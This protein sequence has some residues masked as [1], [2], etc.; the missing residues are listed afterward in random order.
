[1]I[2]HDPAALEEGIPITD[3]S[4]YSSEL[5]CPDSLLAHIFRPAAQSNETIPLLTERIG[6]MREVGF[7]LCAVSQ[8]T[9]LLI[10][11]PIFIFG[12]SICVLVELRRLVSGIFR[13]IPQS[14]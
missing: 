3:P 8:V 6:I 12:N 11:P 9:F 4:F 10:S 1:V 7:I 5:L 2:L 14:A 13:R